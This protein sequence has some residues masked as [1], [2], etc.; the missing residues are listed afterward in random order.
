MTADRPQP[1]TFEVL[2]LWRFPVKSMMGEELNAADVGAFGLLGD[3]AFALVDALDGHVVSAKNPRKWGRLFR[4]RAAYVEPP[5]PGSPLP[6][7]RI[8]LPDGS[9]VR[10]DDP[11]VDRVLSEAVGRAVR[12]ASAAP[13]APRLEEYWPD[14][15]GLPRRDEVTDESMPPGT[16]FDLAPVHLLTTSTLDRLRER[17][18]GGRFEA[19]RFRPNVVV[20]PTEASPGFA[21][22]AWLGRSLAVGERVRLA[23]TGPC[24]RCVMITEPQGDLPADS[25]ILRTAVREHGGNVGVYASVAAAGR[26][27]RG[28]AVRQASN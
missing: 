7:V 15:E 11:D 18:P 5:A 26:V 19:R 10:S 1:P 21:E 20:G 25:S 27:R 14:L 6:P 4:C 28:D 13:E 12:L 23:V 2:S 8:A 17:S 16:F 22:D 24:P 9:E 3:R